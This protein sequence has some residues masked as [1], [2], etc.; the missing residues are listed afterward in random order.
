MHSETLYADLM[1]ALVY[2]L[3]LFVNLFVLFFSKGGG[4]GR[5]AID[6]VVVD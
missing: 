6:P 4:G 1:A 2:S 5:G 3:F